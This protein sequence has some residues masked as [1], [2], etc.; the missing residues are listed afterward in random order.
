MYKTWS[1]TCSG[2]K[3][4]KRNKSKTD[5]KSSYQLLQRKIIEKEE[6]KYKQFSIT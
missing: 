3:V 1:F 4:G 2:L 6:N 5:N